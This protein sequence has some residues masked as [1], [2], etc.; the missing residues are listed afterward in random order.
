MMDLRNMKNP[1]LVQ[2]PDEF[3]Q[4]QK[5][6][7]EHPELLETLRMREEPPSVENYFGTVGAYCEVILDG[8]YSMD[9]L[10]DLCDV[11]IRK[12]REKRKAIIT[13]N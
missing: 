6:V 1:V 7:A 3:L 13:L 8:A 11:L 9:D 4:L 2:I 12:L 5:E 10:I